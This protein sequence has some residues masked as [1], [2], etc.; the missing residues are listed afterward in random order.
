M[1]AFKV[2]LTAC[3]V[4]PLLAACAEAGVGSLQET[5]YAYLPTDIAATSS[6][7]Q[8]IAWQDWQK[9]PHSA[10]YD[11]SKGPNTYCARCHSPL[12]WDQSAKIDPPP[13]CV[14]CKFAFEAKPRIAQGNP[15]VPKDDWKNIGCEV[16]H[17]MENGAVQGE[18]AWLNPITGYHETVI[19]PTDLCEKCHT[20][21]ETLK[22]K[23]A[24]GD[25]A[26]DGFICTSCHNPHSAVASCTQS[27]C[28][29]EISEAGPATSQPQAIYWN[30]R[31]PAH[32]NLACVACHDAS[33]LEV[34]PLE[35]QQ[36][37]M[38]FRTVL[39]LGRQNNEPYQSHDLQ[40]V[41]DC[42]RCHFFGNPWGLN[43][44]VK[45]LDP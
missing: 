16:C 43:D 7:V 13:N 20:N 14:S 1:Q 18:I 39:L 45:G 28:H 12:N 24:L 26:H 17:Q 33:G 25:Q 34:G 31:D 29:I 35:N 44:Q 21:T 2:F 22:H 41:V 3:V 23:R 5:P 11:L 15:L 10:T 6:P 32:V 42:G 8:Q 37:W 19:S 36:V 38:T 9:G 30:H 4:Y 27:G 40:A